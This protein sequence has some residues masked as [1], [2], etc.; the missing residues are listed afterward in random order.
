MEE[1]SA[2][3]SIDS[4]G[5][6]GWD[7]VDKLARAL[8]KLRG[9]CVTNTQ[10]AEIKQLYHSLLEYDKRPLVFAPSVRQ[11]PR[12]R[13]ARSKSQSIIGVDHMKKYVIAL[14]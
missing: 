9:L 10:A 14:Y 13:F 7:R 12:G 1:I 4:R 6:P 5:I 11:A 8:V 2:E 3:D